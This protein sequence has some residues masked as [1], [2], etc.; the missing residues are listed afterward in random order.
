MCAGSGILAKYNYGVFLLALL[1]AGCSLE[2]FRPRMCNRRMW[3]AVL[4]LLLVISPH[5]YWTIT[6]MQA[7]LAQTG[8]FHVGRSVGLLASYVL[9]FH[10]LV[11][12]VVSFLGVLLPVY[13]LFFY[14][15][16]S[17]GLAAIGNK[18]DAALI[19]R[20]LL[21]GTCLCILMILCFKVSVF[22]DRWMQP[23]LFATPIYLVTIPSARWTLTNARRY[24]GFSLLGALAVLVVIAAHTLGAAK[25]GEPGRLNAPYEALAAQ[26]RQAGFT[27]GHIIAQ[28][29]LVGGNLKL[30]FPESVVEA[31][32]VPYFA[33]SINTDRLIVWNATRNDDIPVKLRDFA[34][35]HSGADCSALQP[36]YVQAP[37]QYAPDRTMRLGFLRVCMDAP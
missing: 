20:L 9:G 10:S 35:A 34:A 7:T 4:C 8:K 18:D 29:R 2:N 32:E 13:A 36:Q 16:G 17:R 25:W 22:K 14:Q 6:H 31:P 37:C 21:T 33:V 30:F 15:R 11:M 3:L 12:A 28:D 5:L 24:A 23:L 19:L 27:G 26:L 1:L